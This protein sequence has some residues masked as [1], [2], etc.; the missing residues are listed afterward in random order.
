MHSLRMDV[1]RPRPFIGELYVYTMHQT[2]RSG[3]VK[4]PLDKITK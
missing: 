2:P 1:S 4:V 3:Y